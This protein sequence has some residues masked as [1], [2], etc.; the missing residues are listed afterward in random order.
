MA[1]FAYIYEA[2]TFSRL[3]FKGSRRISFFFFF[4]TFDPIL[5]CDGKIYMYRKIPSIIEIVYVFSFKKKKM[6]QLY[7]KTLIIYVFFFFQ[8]S[9]MCNLTHENTK[10]LPR[11]QVSKLYIELYFK[12]I[13]FVLKNGIPIQNNS[14]KTNLWRF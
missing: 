14:L 2:L 13:N 6:T 8:V 11:P 1:V 12:Q 4:A 5:G 3:L 10:Q 9:R 7:F